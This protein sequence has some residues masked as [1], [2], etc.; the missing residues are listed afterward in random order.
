MATD[1]PF[2]QRNNDQWRLDQLQLDRLISE[3]LINYDNLTNQI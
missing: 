1:H 3:K 2:N